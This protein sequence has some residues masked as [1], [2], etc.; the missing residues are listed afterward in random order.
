MKGDIIKAGVIDVDDDG[1]CTVIIYAGDT[2]KLK[3]SFYQIKG[4]WFN[5]EEEVVVSF[6]LPLGEA[7]EIDGKIQWAEVVGFNI[8]TGFVLHVIFKK[9]DSVIAGNINLTFMFDDEDREKI[10]PALAKAMLLNK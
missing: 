7:P 3:N 9:E 5:N 2:Q 6:K 10:Q 8:D 4:K 1:V